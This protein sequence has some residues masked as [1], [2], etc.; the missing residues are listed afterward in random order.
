MYSGDVK[1][2]ALNL[3]EGKPDSYS[4]S[5]KFEALQRK[6]ISDVGIRKQVQDGVV[7]WEES[8]G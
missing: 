4:Y 3:V 7:H 1:K 2:T 5:V 8:D 6:P